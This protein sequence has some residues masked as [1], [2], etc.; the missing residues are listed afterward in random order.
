MRSRLLLTFILLISLTTGII[1]YVSYERS[2]TMSKQFVEQRLIREAASIG[3]MGEF[4][5]LSYPQNDSVFFQELEFKIINQSIELMADGLSA[6]YFLYIDDEL[7][8]FSMSQFSD[9]SFSPSTLQ[10]IKEGKSGLMH[11]T[12]DSKDFAV[13]YYY[14]QNLQGQFLMVVPTID[15]MNEINQLL[16][17]IA[18]TVLVG[19]LATTVIIIFTVRSITKPLVQ[20]R[21]SMR[22]ARNGDLSQTIDIKST[23]PEVESLV[24]SF[25]QMMDHMRLL[26]LDVKGTTI[27]LLNNSQELSES[28][29]QLNST[30]V[31]LQS[32]INIVN[33]GAEQTASGS[34]RN[35]HVFQQMK[36]QIKKNMNHIE[37][38]NESSKEMDTRAKLGN[39]KLN[40]MVLSMAELQGEFELFQ[41]TMAHVL[42]ESTQIDQ[43]VQLI[44]SISEQTKLLA[45][46]AT[47]EAAR[48]G[49]A[50]KGFAVVAN[51]VRKLAEQTSIAT[52]EITIP[53]TRMK[54][55][56]EQ[57]SIEFESSL[58]NV[59]DQTTIVNESKQ[60]FEFLLHV[61]NQTNNQLVEMREGLVSLEQSV[62]GMEEAT[63]NFTS[64]AQETLASTN[65]IG[66]LVEQQVQKVATFED[67]SEQLK[68]LS[69]S[70]D[71]TTSSFKIR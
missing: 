19:I 62:P 65:E 29:E 48:A 43:V 15:Y 6:D 39:E 57:A 30:A 35:I 55:A 21:E 27:N 58:K 9:L 34:E 32:S 17:I 49:D 22:K 63:S 31:H 14:V 61:V 12:V 33:Q 42:K 37:S 44:Q 40:T 2:S 8:P 71:D 24:K 3:E 23:T 54:T 56:T 45:L 69:Q 10:T 16:T 52:N 41:E 66:M 13:A 46:N 5:K 47:I 68:K 28:S 51:E 20:L 67:M 70:L 4:L 7:T 59:V 64:L 60:A 36:E 25:E 50:G 1:G 38:V 11:M 26:L 18:I 53:I